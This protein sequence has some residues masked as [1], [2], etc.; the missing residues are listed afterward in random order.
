MWIGFR[1]IKPRRMNL[2]NEFPNL[3]GELELVASL[4][5]VSRAQRLFSV[6]NSWTRGPSR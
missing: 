4:L 5:A 3:V 2:A 6:S 1:E